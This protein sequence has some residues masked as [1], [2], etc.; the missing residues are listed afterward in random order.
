MSYGYLAKPDNKTVVTDEEIAKL[1]EAA[2][3]YG[4]KAVKFERLDGEY[5]RL[6]C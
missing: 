2:I 4:G 6:G 1:N 3:D 5:W